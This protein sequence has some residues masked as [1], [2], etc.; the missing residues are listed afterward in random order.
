MTDNAGPL[1]FLEA[2]IV[3]YVLG[4]GVGL[5]GELG[6]VAFLNVLAVALKIAG[7]IVVA[8][9]AFQLWRGDRR[10]FRK[11]RPGPTP[12]YCRVGNRPERLIGHLNT[13]TDD[14]PAFL[15]L[16]AN[17]LEHRNAS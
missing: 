16:A 11:Y 9:A 8:E 2:A 6:D 17:E 12:V 14:A 15:R 4:L 10:P 7:W 13:R 3:V 1:Q 5:A